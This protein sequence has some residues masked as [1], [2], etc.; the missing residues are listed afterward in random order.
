MGNDGNLFVSD[1][2]FLL[3][4]ESTVLLHSIVYIGKEILFVLYFTVF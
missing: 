2:E 4:V 1:T 3:E